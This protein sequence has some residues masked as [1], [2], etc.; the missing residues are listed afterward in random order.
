MHGVPQQRGYCRGRR[1]KADI[2]YFAYRVDF[3]FIKGAS[4]HF[5]ISF[6]IRQCFPISYLPISSAFC[7]IALI[8]FRAVTLA[9]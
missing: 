7:A 3:H 8:A 2:H 9:S 4:A 1:A 5:L 6:Y